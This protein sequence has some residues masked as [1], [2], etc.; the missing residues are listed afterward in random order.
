MLKPNLLVP[1]ALSILGVA[2]SPV[3]THAPLAPV[4]RKATGEIAVASRA[5][6]MGS[7][8]GFGSIT[9]FAIPVCPVFLQGDPEQDMMVQVKAG[10]EH[11]G[12]SVTIVKDAAEAGNRP[13][14]ACHVNKVKFWNYT[15][16]F[17]FVCNWGRFDV[18][19]T[20]TAPKGGILWEKH[21]IAKGSGYYDYKPTVEK[22]LTRLLDMMVKDLSE[23]P[24]QLMAK[25]AET[26]SA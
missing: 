5:E 15:F 20:L 8:A 26:P 22:A 4:A 3:L 23:N 7:L 11:A 17:P 2:C 21:Y 12:Y 25:P 19:L 1:V 9:L 16:F 13:L 24:P 10:L 18:Q 6:N 14:L